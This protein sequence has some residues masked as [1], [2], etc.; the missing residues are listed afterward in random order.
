MESG[1]SHGITHWDSELYR[2]S[3]QI[4]LYISNTHLVVLG[5]LEE[6]SDV[7]TSNDTGL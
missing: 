6:L 2:T 5:V 1:L 4:L 7:L 3:A